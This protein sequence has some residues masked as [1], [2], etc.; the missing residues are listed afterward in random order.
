MQEGRSRE[1]CYRYVGASRPRIFQLKIQGEGVHGQSKKRKVDLRKSTLEYI[2]SYRPTLTNPFYEILGEMRVIKEL[3]SRLP[4]GP[5]ESSTS[6]HS[7]VGQSIYEI[8]LEE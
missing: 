7:Y 5:K 4:Q 1:T 8:Y 2:K 6:R 3:V